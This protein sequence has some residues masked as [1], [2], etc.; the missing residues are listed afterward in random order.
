M[1]SVFAI[2]ITMFE[3]IFLI[4]INNKVTSRSATSCGVVYRPTAFIAPRYNNTDWLNR[5]GSTS[6]VG[7]WD[8][9]IHSLMY[10]LHDDARV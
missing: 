2:L 1:Y 10:Q 3:N 4:Y 7:G 9:L 8:P 6:D 5:V